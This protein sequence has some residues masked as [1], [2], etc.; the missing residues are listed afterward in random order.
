MIKWKKFLCDAF[1]PLGIHRSRFASVH[2]IAHT[3]E[4]ETLGILNSEKNQYTYTH[5]QHT[6]TH[7]HIYMHLMNLF[8][9]EMRLPI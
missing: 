4:R 9:S 8:E 6:Q 3:H 5:T 2:A 1:L 7:A